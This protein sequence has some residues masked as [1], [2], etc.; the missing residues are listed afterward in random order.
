MRNPQK[1][2]RHF[3]SIIIP[4]Y[5]AEGLIAKSLVRIKEVL[6]Q[7]RYP[8]ELICVIDGRVDKTLELA[9]AVAKK[10]PTKIKVVGYEQNLGKGH[11]VRFGM[12]KAKGDIVGFVDAGLEVDP[13]GL[14]MLLEHFEWYNADVIVGS[15]RHPASKV[16]YPWQRRILSFGYQMLCRLLFGLK[17]RDT[18]VGMKFFR[19]EVLE[20]TMPR[21]LVK[22]FAFDIEILSVASY[23]GYER[24]FEAPVE[25]KM[26][27]GGAS[28]IAS[29]G[30]LKTASSM[31]WDTM[32]VFYRLRILRYYDY[33]NRKNW[34]TPQYLTITQGK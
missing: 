6:D 30:F 16:S 9:Q 14:S 10:Y 33:K 23:L 24:I 12:A 1:S 21:L 13:N 28:T 25:L 32:A 26:K 5:K 3:L 34:I 7:V 27:F 20:K 15:K 31:L 2:D 18:Q 29:K 17:V 11:A 19:R 22:A 8:Y 4:A